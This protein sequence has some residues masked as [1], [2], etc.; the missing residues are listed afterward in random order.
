MSALSRSSVFAAACLIASLCGA[1]STRPDG[2]APA[3]VMGDHTHK[4][5]EWMLSYRYFEMQMN[6][7]FQGS[8]KVASNDI[9]MPMPGTYMVAAEDMSMQMH[10]LGAMYAVSDKLT[11]MAMTHFMSNEMDHQTAMGGRFQTAT[12]G[13]ADSSVSGLFTLSE[14]NH[15]KLIV[16]LG[17][18]LPTGS[19]DERDVTPA[20][21]PNTTQ[22]PY[23]M[24]LGS[25]SFSLQ[26]G[27]TYSAWRENYSFGA[28]LSGVFQLQDNDRDYRL[29]D[30][31]NATAWVATPVSE[32]IS[33]SARFAYS[34]WQNI[35]GADASLNPNMIATADPSLRAGSRLDAAIGLNWM[36]SHS[37]GH[38]LR[39]A[40]EYIQALHQ[41]LEG[42]QL[43]TDA[44]LVFTTQYAF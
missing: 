7:N 32:Q 43:G 8:E 31:L 16:R 18:G 37:N 38:S 20:S 35:E 21:A 10:M 36:S 41:D 17:L 5:G 9:L 34:D 30:R 14:A 6:D 40:T 23:P 12:S 24:Q 29:G 15:S 28:Q 2:H 3:A 13:L 19:I 22:L 1:D 4:S 42:P 25:G 33:L 44:Q 39:L 26:P 27:V 11:L